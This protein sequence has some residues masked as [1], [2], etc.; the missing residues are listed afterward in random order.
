M[1]AG[2]VQSREGISLMHINIPKPSAR[3]M[4]PE[5]FQRCPVTGRGAMAIN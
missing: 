3:G 4:V 2:A 5:S 1:E